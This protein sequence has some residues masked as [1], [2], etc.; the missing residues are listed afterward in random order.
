MRVLYSAH[1]YT[2]KKKACHINGNANLVMPTRCY[3]MYNATY[4][5]AKPL[6]IHDIVTV[7]FNHFYCTQICDKIRRDLAMFTYIYL[8]V[9]EC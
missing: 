1:E 9:D 5:P 7:H 4:I 2:F 8:N 3:G 6:H